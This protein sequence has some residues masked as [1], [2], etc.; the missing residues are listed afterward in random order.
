MK[1]VLKL[2]E[3]IDLTLKLHEI[4]DTGDASLLEF[5]AHAR[6]DPE[7]D[8]TEANSWPWKVTELLAGYI[9]FAIGRWPDDTEVVEWIKNAKPGEVPPWPI[10]KGENV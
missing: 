4:D 10:T 5:L 6:K 8:E 9:N 3:L 1:L 7:L 2:S